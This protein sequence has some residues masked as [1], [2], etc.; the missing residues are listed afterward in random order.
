MWGFSAE[1]EA[2]LVMLSAHDAHHPAVPDSLRSSWFWVSIIAAATI[3][4]AV[5][6][7]HD[8]RAA[9]VVILAAT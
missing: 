9:S 7:E 6:D 5:R 4:C 8:G 1:E 2:D 3:H